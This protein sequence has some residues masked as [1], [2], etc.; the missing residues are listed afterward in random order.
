MICPILYL[1]IWRNKPL[2]LK[3]RPF[4]SPNYGTN[5]FP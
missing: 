5:I 3:K 2:P 4:V 1:K